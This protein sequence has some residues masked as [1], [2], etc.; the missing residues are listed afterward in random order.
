MAK[1]NAMRVAAA[2]RAVWSMVVWLGT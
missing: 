2:A 1:A